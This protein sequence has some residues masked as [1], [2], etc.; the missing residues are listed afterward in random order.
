MARPFKYQSPE[1]LEAA[2]EQYRAQ[3]IADEEPVLMTGLVLHLG[4]RS[5][6]TLYNYAGRT[7][8]E[9]EGGPSWA[10]VIQYA[11]L[12]FEHEH[13][14]GLHK[15]GNCGGHVF[16]LKNAGIKT[17]VDGW[18]DKHE[19]E[20]S[21]PNKGPLEISDTERAK[22]ISDLLTAAQQRMAE[23]EGGTESE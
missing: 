4:L 21:G 15:G 3:C 2:I 18:A 22:R 14:K 17:L 7:D 23:E 20:I 5:K 10:E 6:Q 19:H 8:G 9:T 12:L 16:G 11:S 1:H 13:E